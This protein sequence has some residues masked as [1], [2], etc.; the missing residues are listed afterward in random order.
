[1][2]ITIIGLGPGDPS[3]LTREAWE[4][5]S[6]AD[7][8]YL[9]TQKHPTVPALPSGLTLHTFDHLYEKAQNFEQVYTAIA[10]EILSLGHRAQGVIY[11][12]PGHPMVGEASVGRVLDAARE[13]DLAVRV[14]AGLSFVEPVLTALEVDAL[15]GLQLV[16]ATE[17]AL[18]HHPPLNSDVPALIAQFYSQALAADLKLTL[19]N[20]YPPEHPVVLVHSAGTA[21]ERT[22]TVPLYELDRQPDVTHLTT[23]YVPPLPQ[24]SSFEGLQETVAHLRA[25]GGCPWDREQ[26]HQSLRSSL[27]EETYEVLTALDQ[28]NNEALR[29]ELGDLLLQVVLHTQIAVE[30]GEFSMADVIGTV[31]AKL[32]RRHPHVWGER[33]VSGAQEVVRNWELLKAEERRDQAGGDEKGRSIFDS[34]PPTLPALV[35]AYV[36]GRRAARVGFD[37]PDVD[38]IVKQ[39]GAEIAELRDAADDA[40]RTVELGDLLL[41]VVDWAR[42][43]DVDPEAALRQANARFAQRFARMQV[44]RQD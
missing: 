34:V 13:A 19:M 12:V 1:M 37:W 28:E 21:E 3:H 22:V 38:G 20:Q 36:Y 10:A 35:Q 40:E 9:R 30:A 8:V 42:W 29:E 27:L 7:E 15:A 33:A 2:S 32:K 44:E 17:L 14:V 11:A 16:D 26:T 4:V 31:D 24:P 23:L 41:A 5:L 6:A 25:P 39:I 18:M 43:L